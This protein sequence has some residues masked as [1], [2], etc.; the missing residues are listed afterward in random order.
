MPAKSVLV[1]G[2]THNPGGMESVIMNYYRNI[3]PEQIHFDFLTN[4][5]SI[6]YEDEIIEHGSKIFKITAR[7]QNPSKYRADLKDFFEKHA[8]DYDAIW[9]NSCSLA[10]IDYLKYAKRYKIKKRIIHCHNSQN[11]ESVIR[12]IL[13]HINRHL[14]SRYATDYWSCNKIANDWFFGKRLSRK[15]HIIIINNAIDSS[16]FRFSKRNRINKRKELGFNDELVVGH[17]GRFHRQKNQSFILDIFKEIISRRQNAHLVLVG[18]GEDEKMIR[19]KISALGIGD[20]VTIIK[21]RDD[22][23]E[24]LCAFDLFLF[25]SL[26]EGFGLSLLEA[27][28]TNLPCLASKDVIPSEVAVNNSIQFLSLG[29]TASEW[30]DAA[31]AVAG[32]SR[33]IDN[34]F[35]IKHGFDIKTEARKVADF[36]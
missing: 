10:N 24:L 25:P 30:A 34:S 31:M 5:K 6:A 27:E 29:K 36:F 35:I 33:P 16:R 14:I 18:Q 13:H 20:K 11:G 2:M 19:A 3:N 28:A 7:S 21:N 22:I 4:E 1:F 12:H 32:S 26:F 9:V 15:R 8:S 23:P 17:V